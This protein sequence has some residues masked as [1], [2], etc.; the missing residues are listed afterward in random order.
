MAEIL[1]F[2]N[3]D[4]EIHRNQQ[5]KS[6][7]VG[8]DAFGNYYIASPLSYSDS[9]IKKLY[10]KELK[11]IVL[12]LIK[13]T[14]PKSAPKSYTAGELFYYRG[15][16][17]PLILSSNYQDR[18]LVLKDGMF[19]LSSTQQPFA[20]KLFE[21]W[22]KLKLYEQLHLLLPTMCRT[23]NVTP[24][25]INVKNVKTIW[26]SCSA[27]HNITFCTRLSLVP[28]R[29]CEY[30]IVHELCHL[31]YMNHSKAFWNEVGKY[32]PDY[33]ERRAS[34]SNTGQIYKWW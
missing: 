34:L 32:I 5:R 31:K 29:L 9:K 14:L 7:A 18:T 13:R 26:G 6:V 12:R 20:R 19:I 28:E 30:V 3:I 17:Y 15:K 1:Y 4:F 16:E 24:L 22:Y 10:Y 25:S 8:I 2:D 11:P 33:S 21:Q 27:Q 23:I